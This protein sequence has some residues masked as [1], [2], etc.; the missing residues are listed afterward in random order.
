MNPNILEQPI[1]KLAYQHRGFE[2]ER[3]H[4]EI[5]L[6][7]SFGAVS[8]GGT[9]VDLYSTIAQGYD[10]NQRNGRMIIPT[11]V[12]LS[13]PLV[14]GQSNVVADDRHNQFRIV[15]LEGYVGLGAGTLTGAW[16]ITSPAE[17]RYAAGVIR[18]LKDMLISLTSPGPD[19]TGYMPVQVNVAVDVPYHK[20]VLFSSAAAGTT[21]GTT[22]YCY[23][24]SD[25]AAAPNPGF[26]SG[27]LSMSWIE[28]M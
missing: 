6:Q 4:Q 8:T 10:I 2:C 1:P 21:S 27:T 18:V 22:L 26:N 19:S 25:S 3:K 20:R 7:T 14:G 28:D 13:G 15:F 12:T 23:M 5:S 17:P 11:G 9:L 16:G 24:I